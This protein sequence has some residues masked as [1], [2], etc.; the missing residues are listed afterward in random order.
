MVSSLH[1]MGRTK[2]SYG[3]PYYRGPYR[4]SEDPQ[5]FTSPVQLPIIRVFFAAGTGVAVFF[6]ISGYALSVRPVQT[7][8][9]IETETSISK[10]QSL[11]GALTER[12][13]SSI[14]HRGFRL[15]VP[16]IAGIFLFE[17]MDAMGLYHIKHKVKGLWGH[18]FQFLYFLDV[19]AKSIWNIDGEMVNVLRHLWTVPVEFTCSMALFVVIIGISRF[20]TKGRMRCLVGLMCF[21]LYYDHAGFFAFIGGMVIAELDEASADSII[22]KDTAASHLQHSSTDE[23]SARPKR[24]GG[25]IETLFSQGAKK[26]RTPTFMGSA[27]SALYNICWVFILLVSLYVFGWPSINL[28]KEPILRRANWLLGRNRSLALASFAFINCLFRLPWLQPIFTKP[29][30]LYLGNISYSVY[31]VH[32]TLVLALEDGISGHVSTIFGSERSGHLNR[33][34]ANIYEILLMQ[35]VVIWASDLFFR[36][37]DIPVLKLTRRM[38]QKYRTAAS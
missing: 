29:F 23:A 32:Y 24:D 8:R 19:M 7:I 15:F 36:L 35:C 12:L 11:Q 38:D 5:D 20:S 13:S 4:D 17:C 25:G 2:Y 37:V 9:R 31:C 33:F 16:C 30:A 34:I 18:V 27:S 6:V 22:A 28:E 1:Q 21:A 10:K 14:F 26:P 3:R